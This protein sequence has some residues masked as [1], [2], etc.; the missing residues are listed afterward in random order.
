MDAFYLTI[1]IICIVFLIL[2][3]VFFGMMMRT[4]NKGAP[5]PPNSNKCPDYWNVNLDGTCT[6]KVKSDNTY[7]N[8][9]LLTMPL[10]TLS[11][12]YATNNNTFDPSDVKWSTSG[13]STLCAQRDWSLQQGVEWQGISNYNGC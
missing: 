8:T 13:K 11:A 12:P 1:T 10:P 3:L 9:G 4:H 6:A 2:I 5:F 7:L